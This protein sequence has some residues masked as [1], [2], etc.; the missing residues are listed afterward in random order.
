ME[1]KVTEYSVSWIRS[2]AEERGRNADW[3]ESAVRESASLTDKDA[4]E[5]NVIDLRADSLDSLLDQIDGMVVKLGDEEITLNTQGYRIRENEMSFIQRLLHAISDPNIAY[6]LLSIGSLGIILELYSPG[7]I[8]PGVVGAIS[9]LMAFYSLSVLNAYWAG[10]ILIFLA[11]AM[12]TA[13]IFTTSFGLLTAGGIASLVT[14]SVILFSGGPS[15]F[16]LEIDWWVILIVVVGI[17][18]FFGFVIQAV[19]RTQRQK[20]PTGQEGLIGMVAEVRSTLNPKGTVLVH[21]ELWEAV[22]D[23]GQAEPGEEVMVTD[24]KGLRLRVVKNK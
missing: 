6:I 20:Q 23:E 14:G 15:M 18:A 4:L 2:I 21:G 19:V 17:V 7:T 16:G 24:V 11:F 12:F 9:L 3:A 10:I 13:E 1:E 22:L 5:K 8:I